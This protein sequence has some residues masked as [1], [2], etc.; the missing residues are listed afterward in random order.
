MKAVILTNEEKEILEAI[1]SGNFTRAE[2][3]DQL[4]KDLVASAKNT[5][6]K[7]KNIN[8][9][10]SEKDLH[11]VKAKASEAGLPYQ[12]YLS[13]VIHQVVNK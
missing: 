13:S 2:N 1:E 10:L 3:A 11:K 12:T 4:K 9:R 7:T 5:V 6:N 8:L